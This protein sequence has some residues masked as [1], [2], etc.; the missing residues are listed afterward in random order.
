MSPQSESQGV[1]WDASLLVT[2]T[3]LGCAALATLF[4]GLTSSAQ[5]SVGAWS[6]TVELWFLFTCATSAWAVLCLVGYAVALVRQVSRGG[7]PAPAAL[8]AAVATVAII[9][10]LVVQGTFGG[11]VTVP[12]Q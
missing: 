12:P 9:A 5:Q 4:N 8:A 2:V 6:E 11:S 10:G 3:G 7:R 1:R